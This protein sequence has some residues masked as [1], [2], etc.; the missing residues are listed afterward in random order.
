MAIPEALL[1]KELFE[2]NFGPAGS[3]LLTR[4]RN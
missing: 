3:I 1:V 4:F 2:L